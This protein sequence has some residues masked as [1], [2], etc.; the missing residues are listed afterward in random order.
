M[1]W[2]LLIEIWLHS[3][4]SKLNCLNLHALKERTF[5]WAPKTI[6]LFGVNGN[7]QWAMPFQI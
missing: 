7:A 2:K 1:R 5:K 6:T 3:D 4:W